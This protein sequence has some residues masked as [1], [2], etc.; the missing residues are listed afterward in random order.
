[1]TESSTAGSGA[2]AEPRRASVETGLGRAEEW[3]TGQKRSLY[4]IAVTR[5]ILGF[6]VWSQLVA[7]WPDRQ[8][9]WG[10]GARWTSPV[11]DQAG[12]PGFLGAF[13][14]SSGRGFDALYLVTIVAGFSLMLGWFTRAS[15]VL[16]LVLWMSLYVTNPFVG[17]GGD[18]VLRMV[19]LYLCFTDAGRIWSLDARRRVRRAERAEGEVEPRR[20]FVPT[21]MSAA[22]HNLALVLI[23]H[24]V[25]M[26]YVGSAF[27]KLS[28]PLWTDGTA[29]YYPLQTE[30]F[31]PWGDLLH[32][33]I[34][35][36]PFVLGGT[37]V[38]LVVQLFFPVFL[39]YRPTR[40]MALIAITGMHLG[41]GLLMG[42]LYFSLVMIAVDMILV[43]DQSWKMA[44]RT[45]TSVTKRVR[46]LR[47][48]H[49]RS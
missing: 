13:D 4:G 15:A 49:Q 14:A 17:S 29:V 40:F 36:E 27:W 8:Y 24:Q 38:A 12:W 21:W 39:I 20:S 35:S 44:I 16:T 34:A 28:G 5:M 26:V 47:H 10:D 22:V 32:P 18:A 33:L 19:L 48:S 30:A 2:T 42:I 3:L 31:S 41:I 43:S 1:M 9:T 7:N 6:V 23:I 11:R 37:Y 25:V 45:L 46:G